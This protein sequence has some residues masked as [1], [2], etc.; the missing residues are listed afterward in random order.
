MSER[1]D[2]QCKHARHQHGTRGAYQQDRC[3]CFPCRLANARAKEQYARGGTWSESRT[4]PVGTTRRLRALYALGWTWQ[5]LGDRLGVQRQVVRIAAS[6]GRKYH[7]IYFEARVRE[8]YDEI[9]MISPRGTS[10]HR[11]RLAAARK[12]WAVPLAWDD[13]IDDPDAEPY[14][15]RYVHA[16]DVGL[17]DIAIA[18]A[19]RGR[20]VRLTSAER[21]EAVQRMTARGYSAQVIAERLNVTQ[22]CVVRR[23]TATGTERVA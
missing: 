23:R 19:M 21:A 4:N 10:A 8:L 6:G 9:S 15:D 11:A 18:E 22:R 12:G 14:R 1:R 3:R 5:A 13:D 17:D 20:P 7:Y 2:C 16:A